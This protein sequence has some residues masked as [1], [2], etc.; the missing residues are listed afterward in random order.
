MLWNSLFLI[1]PL[2]L[3]GRDHFIRNK[4]FFVKLVCLFLIKSTL[5]I[6]NDVRA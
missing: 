4:V 6:E 5:R 1:D 3:S 2:G